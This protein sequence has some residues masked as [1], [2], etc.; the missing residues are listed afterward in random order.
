MSCY[1]FKKILFNDGLLNNC[2][3]VTYII[4]L[5]ENGRY[6]NI[7]DQLNIY[8][9][10]NIVYIVF[11]KGYKK[12]FKKN[13]NNTVHDIIFT[14]I[15]IFEHAVLNNYNNILVLED[16][17][18]FSP[19]ILE[20]QHTNNISNFI[21][22]INTK[23][24]CFLLGCLP[25]FRIPCNYNTSLV[26]GYVA[27]HSCIYSRK[28]YRKI[29]KDY[30][31]FNLIYSIEPYLT[32][33]NNFNNFMYNIPLCYQLFPVTENYYN[34]TK[35][36]YDNDLYISYISNISKKFLNFINLDVNVEPGYTFFYNLSISLFFF[37]VFLLL[38]FIYNMIN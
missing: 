32:L 1:N 29:I 33:F 30:Y 3:D 15:Q 6:S 10:T 36:I 7:I 11:N 28:L 35:D 9:P 22:N 34:W 17:F 21:N 19:K 38:Y 25:V 24:F 23:T 37:T 8:H 4:H 14:N 20:S 16:D 12:C 18:M 26:F 5:E 2:V 31:N 13:V 27:Q